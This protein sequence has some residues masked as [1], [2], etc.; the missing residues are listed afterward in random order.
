M[1]RDINPV[2]FKNLKAFLGVFFKEVNFWPLI[3][4]ISWVSGGM[5]FLFW[6]KMLFF[7]SF[8]LFLVGKHFWCICDAFQKSLENFGCIS[9]A[10]RSC[11]MNAAMWFVPSSV[12]FHSLRFLMQKSSFFE[13]YPSPV[14]TD[15][16]DSNPSHLEMYTGNIIFNFM[17]DIPRYWGI[18]SNLRP[19]SS[20]NK[21]GMHL[22]FLQCLSKWDE[23]GI[24]IGNI[25][26]NMYACFDFY[27]IWVTE[28]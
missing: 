19:F 21:F 12:P 4:D 28:I 15:Q 6:R 24:N 2:I 7:G 25:G 5:I 16:S 14:G 10:F 17:G 13:I 9:D 1:G 8:V 22:G 20:A 27:S 18:W 23:F 26:R 11:D 3:L